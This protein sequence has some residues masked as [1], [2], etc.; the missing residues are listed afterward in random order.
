VLAEWLAVLLFWQL[1]VSTLGLVNQAFLPAPLTILRAAVTMLSG[2]TWWEHAAYSAVNWVTGYGLATIAGVVTGLVIGTL[3]RA[4]RLVVP[5]A[6]SLYATPLVAI[7][8]MT[9]VWFGFGAA[10]IIFLIFISALVPVMLNSAAGIRTVDPS[11][12]RAARVFG[13]SQFRVYLKIILPSTVPYIAA[14]MR[15]AIP[16]SLIGMLVGELVGSPKG[17]G[18]VISLASSTFRTDQA[19]AAV[20]L[21]VIVS[22][23]L[24]RGAER[25]QRRLAPW[26]FDAAHGV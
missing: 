18:A 20:V 11:L 7:R 19:L 14:G 23:T 22:V 17:I 15:L 8:P 2:S 10:P 6:W 5:L 26:H 9:V 25:L 24:V 16:A 13:A 3:P 21:L 1:S 4:Y 12:V